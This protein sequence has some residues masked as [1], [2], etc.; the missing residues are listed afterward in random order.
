MPKF[1]TTRS[2]LTKYALAC[3]YLESTDLK[4]GHIE[5]I[6]QHG[7]YFVVSKKKIINFPTL[8]EARRYYTIHGGKFDKVKRAQ[9][10]A[11]QLRLKTLSK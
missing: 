3:G 1:Y 11:C 6:L 2:Q 10:E 8:R 7:Q 5:L 9:H 4:E